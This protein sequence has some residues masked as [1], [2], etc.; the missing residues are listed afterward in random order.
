MRAFRGTLFQNLSFGLTVR[1]A[2]NTRYAMSQYPL[3][4]WLDEVSSGSL[5]SGGEEAPDTYL[6]PMTI[7]AG[8]GYHIDM[9][10]LA[11]ILDPTVHL[12]LADPLG[13]IRENRSPWALLHIGTEA[14]VLRFINLRAGVNQGYLTAGAGVK[15]LFLT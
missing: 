13:V 10:G 6:V 15:L 14:K 7:S 4:D 5:P 1:D 12:E 2:F 9:G 11:R 8:L 3:G